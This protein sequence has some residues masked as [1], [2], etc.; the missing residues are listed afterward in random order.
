[1]K[2]RYI[3]ELAL[4]ILSLVQLFQQGQEIYAQGFLY[5]LKN[6][7]RLKLFLN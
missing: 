1:M 4:V 3:S 6:L 5:Y 2:A 7:V